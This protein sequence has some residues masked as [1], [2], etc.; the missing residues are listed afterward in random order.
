[1]NSYVHIYLIKADG[2]GNVGR[3]QEQGSWQG[4]HFYPSTGKSTVLPCHRKPFFK[5]ME[6]QYFHGIALTV[7]CVIYQFFFF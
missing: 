1:M 6:P 7:H 4:S 2:L 3:S 5:E